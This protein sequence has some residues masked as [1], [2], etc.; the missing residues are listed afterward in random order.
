M[1]RQHRHLAAMPLSRVNRPSNVMPS[2]H[3]GY[4][5]IGR[6]DC[7]IARRDPALIIEV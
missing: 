5:L 1:A 7:V 6:R 3:H 2:W 4:M